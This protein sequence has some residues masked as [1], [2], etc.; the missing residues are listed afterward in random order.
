MT[1]ETQPNTDAWD[2]FLGKWLKPEMVKEWPAKF[3][4]ISVR[5]NFD[6]EENAHVVYTGEF[7]GKKKDWEPNKTNIEI[8]RN[9]GLISPKALIGK[10]IYFRKVMNFNPQIKKKVPSFEIERIE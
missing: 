7:D 2:D 10:I 9:L 3:I 4:P 5:A 1:N 6:S 8:L